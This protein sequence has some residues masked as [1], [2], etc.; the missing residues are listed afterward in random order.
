M[1]SVFLLT[2]TQI[3]KSRFSLYGQKK[4]LKIDLSKIIAG[5]S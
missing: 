1:M 2:Y 5:K 3:K 4:C